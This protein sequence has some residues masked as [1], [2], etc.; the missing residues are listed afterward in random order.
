MPDSDCAGKG[1]KAERSGASCPAVLLLVFSGKVIKLVD[2]LR[3]QRTWL[4][5]LSLPA[6]AAALHPFKL[7]LIYVTVPGRGGVGL[8]GW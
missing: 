1:I 2:R 8:G 5:T 7:L 3:R 6:F 4:C